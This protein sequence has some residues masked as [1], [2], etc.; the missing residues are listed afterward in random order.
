MEKKTRYGFEI[1]RLIYPLLIYFGVQMIVGFVYTL[2]IGVGIGMEMATSGIADPTEISTVIIDRMLADALIITIITNALSLLIFIPLYFGDRKKSIKNCEFV[3]YENYEIL[4]WILVAVLGISAALSL[5]I[6]ISYS[7]LAELSPGF[8]GVSEAIYGS[9][10]IIQILAT[11]IS[12]PLLEEFLVRGLIYKRMKRWSSPL[13]AAI[14][15]SALFGLIHM[16][17]VQFVYAFILGF[18]IALVYE[19]FENIWAPILFHFAANAVSIAI[20]NVP[21]FEEAFESDTVTLIL[22][23]VT[24]L[25]MVALIIYFIKINKVKGEKLDDCG[26]SLGSQEEVQEREKQLYSQEL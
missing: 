10:V 19:K 17:L 22:F 7:G 23:I 18:M 5:N 16:N 21:F 3:K 26:E 12:A 4:K 14:I 13:L 9:S 6:I 11:V 1:W 24:T 15:S 2:I 25:A 20:S 8:E